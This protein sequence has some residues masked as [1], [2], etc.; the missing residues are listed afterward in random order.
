LDL[1]TLSKTISASWRNAQKNDQSAVKY[2]AKLAEAELKKYN[3]EL[4][5]WKIVRQAGDRLVTVT[6]QK[7]DKPT[8][9]KPVDGCLVSP[10]ELESQ[11]ESEMHRGLGV[12]QETRQQ[13][14]QMKLKMY[15]YSNYSEPPMKVQG[16]LWN[17]GSS[18]S[19]GVQGGNTPFSNG[20][21]PSFA[22]GL[23]STSAEAMSRLRN[24]YYGNNSILPGYD[25]YPPTVPA[26]SPLAT[27]THLSSSTRDATVTQ[28]ARGIM[29]MAMGSS[30]TT[31]NVGV[32]TRGVTPPNND[33]NHASHFIPSA[34]TSS[35]VPDQQKCA[36]ISSDVCQ[37]QH[38]QPKTNNPIS[39][40]TPSDD[41][42]LDPVHNFPRCHCI[43]LFEST[44]DD[45]TTSA[46]VGQVGLRCFYCKEICF[47][48]TRDAIYENVLNFQRNHLENCP[49]FPEKMK[50]K[51]KTLIQR[52]Y[53]SQKKRLSYDFLKAYYAEAAREIGLVDSPRGLVFGA[54]Q[55]RSGV[56]S[57][58]LQAL[59]DAAESCE[60]N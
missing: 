4:K 20:L 25:G 49:C 35:D 11:S 9:D 18:S 28:A 29:A 51:Y 46:R 53:W 10:S 2:C 19:S 58:R 5:R 21:S 54:P 15:L 30:N 23:L 3:D 16:H 36:I 43:Q 6:G 41:R 8:V 57:E 37:E 52:E 17:G 13:L 42:V 7:V 33:K 56:P 31:P 38:K 26:L 59:V 27:G 24:Q 40:F 22:Y 44:Q 32:G 1:K 14:A 48:S 39:L 47:P 45:H 34:V 12:L 50:A 60:V 55:S